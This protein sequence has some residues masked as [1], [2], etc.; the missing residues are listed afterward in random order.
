MKLCK[1]LGVADVYVCGASQ[2]KRLGKI[3][4]CA[5]GESRTNWNPEG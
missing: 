2:G 3:N 4:A 5:V 1:S